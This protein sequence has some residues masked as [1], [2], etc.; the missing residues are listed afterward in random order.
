[1]LLIVLDTARADRCS[2]YG[3]WRDTTPYLQRLAREAIVFDDAW[4]PAPWTVPAHGSL[5][6]GRAPWE[7]GL[8][9][10]ELDAIS[11]EIPTLAEIL[12]NEGYGTLCVTA[13]PWI[14]DVSGLHRDFEEYVA[15]FGPGR[16]GETPVNHAHAFEWMRARRAEGK[17][18]FAFVNDMDPHAPY[19]PQGEFATRF[20]PQDLAVEKVREGRAMTSARGFA[21]SLGIEPLDSE[22]RRAIGALYDG[23][24]GALDFEIGRLLE[25]M[26]AEGLL[27]RTLVVLV[28]DHGEG[29]ADHGW[30]EH[31]FRVDREVLR[32]PLVVRLPGGARGGTRV[33]DVVEI[34]DVFATVLEAC[35]VAL[36][37]G[38]SPHTLLAPVPGRVAIGR[39]VASAD[40]REAVAMVTSHEAT[41]LLNRMR[42]SAFD[43]RFHL[44]TEEGARPQLFD[45]T[46][47]PGE[48]RDLAKE[49]PDDVARLLRSLP[50]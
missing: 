44:V 35:G 36:P 1:V 32:V 20:L 5:F 30:I 13:N 16:D 14:S 42:G 49:R 3:H 22:F 34:Q 24:I 46:A 15:T 28:G 26:R 12:R 27:D 7:I 38:A 18:F 4:S 47:D 19:G 17:P 43:G 40:L 21:M 6:T 10:R 39:G 37:K 8:L 31:S 45:V 9:A 11:P 29:L 48:Q 23:E 2:L 33:K 50:D 41:K 25:S